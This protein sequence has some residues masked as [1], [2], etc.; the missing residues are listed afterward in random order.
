MHTQQYIF[1]FFSW[2]LAVSVSSGMGALAGVIQL[3]GYVASGATLIAA[4]LSAAGERGIGGLKMAIVLA[5]VAA[6]AFAVSQWLFTSFGAT[7]NITPQ[8]P[9]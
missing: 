8:T 4:G 5:G 1:T 3:I 7:I 6:G 2:F 9:N